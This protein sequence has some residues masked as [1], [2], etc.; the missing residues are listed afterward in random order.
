ML[1]K[2]SLFL[3][4]IIVTISIVSC[5]KKADDKK[6]NQE[7][8]NTEV[9]EPD[10]Y[11]IEMPTFSKLFSILDFL[12]TKDFD[13]ALHQEKITPGKDLYFSAFALGQLSADAVIATKGR[14]KSQ[15]TSFSENM[16]NFSLL[17]GIQD[18]IL[19]LT[20]ELQNL[21]KTD[22]WTKLEQTLDKYKIDVEANL[23]ENQDYDV[24]TLLQLGGWTEGLNRICYLLKDNYSREKTSII[25]QR[26]T[27]NNLLRNLR[28]MIDPQIQKEKFVQISIQKFEEIKKIIIKSDTYSKEDITKIYDLTEDIKKT[29]LQ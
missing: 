4:V 8:I 10:F 24:L 3:I 5:G 17:I 16:T 23:H 15:L 18:E 1:K 25:N 7:E 6:Q 9:Q 12:E 14:N 21:I 19:K 28:N 11:L 26:G 2:I 27:L 20:D 22:S 13:T 29:V